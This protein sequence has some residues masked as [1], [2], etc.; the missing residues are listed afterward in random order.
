MS[1]GEGD[2]KRGG[3]KRGRKKMQN[4]EQIEKVLS[5]YKS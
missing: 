5:D 1:N 2:G 3:G 4:N